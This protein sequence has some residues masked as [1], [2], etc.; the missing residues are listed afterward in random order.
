M[1]WSCLSNECVVASDLLVLTCW[2]IWCSVP[3]MTNTITELPTEAAVQRFIDEALE[4]SAAVT[5]P[6]YTG[7]DLG[8]DAL[9][10]DVHVVAT[11]WSDAGSLALCG[12]T[13]SELALGLRESLPMCPMCADVLG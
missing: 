2:T 10:A 7:S 3:F 13:L 6:L 11:R 5:H 4:R 1:G 8:V 9:E 12:E